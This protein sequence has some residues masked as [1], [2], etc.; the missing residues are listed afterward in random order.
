M[1]KG[2]CKSFLSAFLGIALFVGLSTTSYAAT[3]TATGIMDA[4]VWEE[5]INCNTIPGHTSKVW[6]QEGDTA[7]GFKIYTNT[8]KTVC[9]NQYTSGNPVVGTRVSTWKNETTESTQKWYLFTTGQPQNKFFIVPILNKNVFIEVY[10]TSSSASADLIARL[11]SYQDNFYE[12]CYIYGIMT[13][14]YNGMVGEY[15]S[16]STRT[17]NG[18]TFPTRQLKISSSSTPV[19][20][21]NGTSK[22]CTWS[23]SGNIF[24]VGDAE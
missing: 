10:R 5:L 14:S 22:Y 12:D 15:M 7:H 17:T 16:L 24:Y 4:S 3:A 19:S 21:G 13:G 18:T 11:G 23:S 8:N 2:I 20:D 6:D 9:L 1:K